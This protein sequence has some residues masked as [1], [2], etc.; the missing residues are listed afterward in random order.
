[1]DD[2]YAA[3]P[4]E[5]QV[6]I[7]SSRS[8]KTAARPPTLNHHKH[9]WTSMRHLGWS[10]S[11]SDLG[12]VSHVGYNTR[13]M[14]HHRRLWRRTEWIQMRTWLLLSIFLLA[15]VVCVV[16]F[17]ALYYA[18]GSECYTT[19]FSFMQMMWL[20]THVFT[21][22]GFGSISPDVCAGPQLL[23]LLEHFIAIIETALFTAIIITKF[24][25]PQPKVRFSKNF[26]VN[27]DPDG[28]KWLVFRMVRESPHHLR[29]CRLNVCCGVVT[30]EGGVVT[31]CSEE[32]L[33][34][35]CAH[36]SNLE[37]W[38][39]RH[40]ID[41]ASPL[42]NERLRELAYMNVALTVFDTAHMQEVRIYH[43]YVPGA[44]MMT[45]ARFDV[46]KTWEMTSTTSGP[47]GTLSTFG[48]MKSRK[49]GK[50]TAGLIAEIRHV[51]D[52]SKLDAISLLPV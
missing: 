30:R 26:L 6:S 27:E 32:D 11:H 19:Q 8:N 17:A 12:I 45:S 20:S 50:S 24:T 14:N 52:H 48:G 13:H 25:Q 38:F 34:L 51:V 7:A 2:A 46:M 18:A 41:D 36:K 15:N 23:V 29:D 35:Q 37:T 21:T 40:R 39:V 44:D 31:G 47:G 3:S 43:N 33:P 1:M 10:K 16:V 4:A 49:G 22:V 9:R 28:S 5:V 42:S